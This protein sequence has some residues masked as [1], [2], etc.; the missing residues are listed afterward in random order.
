[1]PEQKI[2]NDILGELVWNS[3]L[4][5]WSNQVEIIPGN[6]VNLSV[7]IDDTEIP[8]CHSFTRIQAQE[9][10]LRRFAANQLLERYN[11]HWNNGTE[12][13]CLTF[14]ELIK[15]VSVH[16]NTDGSADLFYDDGELFGGHTIIISIDCNGACEDAQI[17][18]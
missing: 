5:W 9:I 4:Q 15:L 14:I 11:K 8:A 13:D 7:D 17:A 16:I 6:I 2:Q 1:M 3:K 18:G 10:N 12:I